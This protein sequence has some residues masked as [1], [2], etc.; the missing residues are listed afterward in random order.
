MK[1]IWPIEGKV[2]NQKKLIY[3]SIIICIVHVI[4]AGYVHLNSDYGGGQI[5]VSYNV[6]E[7]IQMFTLM[8]T[9]FSMIIVCFFL[10]FYIKPLLNYEMELFIGIFLELGSFIYPMI[11]F[12][13]AHSWDPD[14]T[15]RYFASYSSIIAA[16]LVVREALNE[17]K[18]LER[19]D[20]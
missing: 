12:I 11:F 15:Y 19:D 17:I 2:K 10:S 20:S 4:L 3:A 8:T 14:G 6:P 9:Y 18:R 13:S 5:N 7:F 16:L 1:F